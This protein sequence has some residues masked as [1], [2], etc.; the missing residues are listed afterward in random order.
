MAFHLYSIE[1]FGK[2]FNFLIKITA[3]I[4]NLQTPWSPSSILLEGRILTARASTSSTPATSQ[5]HF[6]NRFCRQRRS[7][8]CFQITGCDPRADAHLA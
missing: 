6:P 5:Q 4:K 1:R 7:Q 8:R 2:Q 3:K